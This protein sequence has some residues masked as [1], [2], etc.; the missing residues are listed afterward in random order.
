MDSDSSSYTFALPPG[1]GPI[2]IT[3]ELRFRRAF[4]AVIDAKGWNTPDVVMEET[5]VIWIASESHRLYLP[6]VMR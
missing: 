1:G 3:A 6:L 5:Q 4:Q 2:T